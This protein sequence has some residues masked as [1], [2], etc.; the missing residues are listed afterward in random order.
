MTMEK[1]IKAN[2]YGLYK[3]AVSIRRHLHANPELSFQENKTSEFVES[4][5][6]EFGIKNI[7]RVGITGLTA[8]IKGSKGGNKMLALRADL[9]ALPIHELN[10]KVYTSIR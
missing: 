7:K 10:K 3:E 9:D 4:K 8:E 5:L 2:A 1:D 6:K